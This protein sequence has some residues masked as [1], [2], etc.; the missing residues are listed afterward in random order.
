MMRLLKRSP[1]GDI[2]LISF[3]DDDAPPYAILS[4]TWTEGQEV[5]YHEL[6]NSTGKDKSGYTKI[7]FCMDRASE[8]GIEYCWVDT[9]CI[10]KSDSRELHTAIN[11]MFHWYRRAK[12]CYVYLSDV[13][14][15]KEVN[16]AQT[17]RISWVQAFR[18]SKWF[19][20]GWT[21]Q[22]LPVYTHHVTHFRS[23]AQ[24]LL[25]KDLLCL[26]QALSETNKDLVAS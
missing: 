16:D 14:M 20:R 22:E 15:L 3:N 5:T 4:H 23:R 6:I 13:E 21:L 7:C 12:Q 18:R 9:C 10:D 17:F 25:A 1:S 2:K 24:P 19:T 11:S 8:D 26:L